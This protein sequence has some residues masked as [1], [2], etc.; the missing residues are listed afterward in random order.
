MAAI[1]RL[2]SRYQVIEREQLC[3]KT[4]N[5]YITRRVSAGAQLNV[6]ALNASRLNNLSGLIPLCVS[7]KCLDVRLGPLLFDPIDITKF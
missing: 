7:R 6:N 4:I 1:R 5:T 3:L 2:T